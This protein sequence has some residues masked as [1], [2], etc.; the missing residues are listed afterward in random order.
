MES[1]PTSTGQNLLASRTARQPDY[2]TEN[3]ALVRLAKAQTGPRAE[4]LN[5]IAE[6]ALKLSDAGS[7]GISLVEGAGANRRFRWLAVAGICE[8]L[9]GKTTAWGDCP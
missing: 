2:A 6:T 9:K 7:A 4:L 3:Q 8:G 5:A 1:S